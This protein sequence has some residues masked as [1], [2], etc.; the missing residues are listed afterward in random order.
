[1]SVVNMMDSVIKERQEPVSME[2]HE[3]STIFPSFKDTEEYSGLVES[4][5]EYGLNH[6]IL[7]W[8]GKIIDGRHRHMA[9]KEAG[10]EPEYQYLPDDTDFEAVKDRVVA[11]NFLR[12]ELTIGQ[13][14]MTA[15]ALANMSVGRN[16]DQNSNCAN[17]RDNTSNQEAADRLGVSPRSVKTAKEVKRDA[18][19]LAAKVSDG[20][21]TLNAA[22]QES[23]KR[24]NFDDML[25]DGDIV[26]QENDLPV[27]FNGKNFDATASAT[28]ILVGASNLYCS[29]NETVNDLKM[30]LYSSATKGTDRERN[31]YKIV[32]LLTL[33]DAINELEGDL[34]EY[35]GT[36]E[37]TH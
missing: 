22:R 7:V 24:K 6:P 27:W 5:K 21:M 13:R 4:I 26:P 30:Y 2:Y 8:Q 25:K 35:L 14:A 3:L 28:S 12:R 32:S 9:C 1:M 36:T 29:G 18:P 16:W 19:D 23:R 37:T 20:S 31:D 34:K 15:S 10:V 17:L 11:E 33:R